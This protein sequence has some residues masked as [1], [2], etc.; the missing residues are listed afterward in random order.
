M[1]LMFLRRYTLMLV[2]VLATALGAAK[3]AEAFPVAEG[4][5]TSQ[6][7][8]DGGEFGRSVAI[9]GDLVAVGASGEDAVYVYKWDGDS[10]QW[11]QTLT[12]PPPEPQSGAEFGRAVALNG[13]LLVVGA[14]FA[15]ATKEVNDEE[16]TVA[17]AGAVYVFLRKAG[18]WEFEA[19]LTAGDFAQDGGNFGR[20]L[21]LS[22]NLL[23]VTARKEDESPT[24]PDDG[25]AY[26]F[27]RVGKSWTE[28]VRVTPDPTD[29][30][31]GGYFGQ[32]V[33]LRGNLMVVGAR[34]DNGNEDRSG[35][36]Y[37]FNRIRN[38]WEQTAKLTAS[39]G[40][41]ESGDQFGFN[42][43][44][45]GDLVAVG[46][47]RAGGGAGAAYIFKFTGSAWDEIQRLAG[48]PGEEFGQGVAM[49][50]NFLAVS[51]WR[52]T[53]DGNARQG[54]VYLFP[55]RGEQWD[56][57][58]V[59]KFEAPDG[60]RGDQLGHSLAAHGDTIIA[61]ANEVGFSNALGPGYVYIFSK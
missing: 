28:P 54:A 13:N 11:Q 14:R 24:E 56:V 46:A 50:G 58:E 29:L 30:A 12:A 44:I 41:S 17:N 32:S 4:K 8:V 23:V 10:Y 51:A 43:A 55:R 36:A 7:P 37:V 19:K 45:E 34:N 39:E 26:V 49:A 3:V 22:G 5:L 2:L 59:R 20:A 9:D 27:E 61:G 60:G 53:I 33:A 48:Q 18:S 40:E 52:A 21:A 47:R 15:P 6:N 31:T 1:K 42:L 57:G 38:E 35:S 25:A 16:V